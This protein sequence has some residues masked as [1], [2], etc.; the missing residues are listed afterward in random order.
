MQK[1]GGSGSPEVK[2]ERLEDHPLRPRHLPHPRLHRQVSL[3]RAS[4]QGQQEGR[5]GYKVLLHL[6][7]NI[8]RD[9]F[10]RHHKDHLGSKEKGG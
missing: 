6:D 8:R 4:E 2:V 7:K 1:G 5:G 3:L 9:L 10:H